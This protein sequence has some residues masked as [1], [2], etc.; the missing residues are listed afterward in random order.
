MSVTA[1]T[2]R[3]PQ[4]LRATSAVVTAVAVAAGAYALVPKGGDRIDQPSAGHAWSAAQISRYDDLEANK[5]RA[6]RAFGALSG[7]V[8]T[9]SRYD[10]LEANKARGMRALGDLSGP[11]VT[12][13]RYRDLEANKARGMR[14]LGA[15]SG[16]V[17]AVSPHADLEANKARGMRALGER[18][19]THEL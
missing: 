11:A 1:T 9:V 7:A 3:T 12:V 16:P 13:T 18:R 15:V 10:D 6:A 4:R 5:A 19:A 2:I 17:V 8:V 14:A